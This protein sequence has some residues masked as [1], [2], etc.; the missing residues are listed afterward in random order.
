MEFPGCTRVG[1]SVPRAG[2]RTLL[3][4]VTVSL[5]VGLL[6][7][8]GCGGDGGGDQAQAHGGA[9]GKGK[10]GGRGEGRAQQPP[11]PVAVQPVEIGSIAS[12]YTATA[13]LAAEKEAEVLARVAG[14]VDALFCEEGDIVRKGDEL[15]RI[16]NDEY[17]Y[18]LQQAEADR[19]NLESRY[20]RVQK[21]IEQKLVS[22][23]EFEGVKSDLESARAAEGLA[24]LSLSYTRV[25]APFTGRVVTRHIDVGQNINPG[26]A[27]FV[28]SDFNPLL[29]RI[30]VPAREFNKLNVEQ[31]VDLMLESSGARLAGRIKL[32]SPVID[33]STGTIKVTVEITDY[34][35]GTRPGDFAKVSIVTER[36]LGSTLVPKIAI[37]TDRGERVVYVAA[38][39]STAE[40]RVVEVG[41][42][43][44]ENAEII[45]GVNEGQSVVVRGQRSL[46]HGQSIKILNDEGIVTDDTGEGEKSERDGS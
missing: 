3:A 23:E 28:L 22:A 18:R 31:P 2:A 4:A 42:E 1:G 36:R 27:L 43:D 25:V 40:R 15:L 38:A 45:S 12:Y 32:I 16:D 21:M 7:M 9:G 14:V 34:P 5:T 33:P 26:T 30:H 44:D 13:T 24:R 6:L 11:V 41:F 8:A 29:A 46:K 10:G 20:E 39:D 37:V 17:R 19:A 35:A